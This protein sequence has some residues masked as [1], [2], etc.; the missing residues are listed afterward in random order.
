MQNYNNN[1]KDI[2]ECT[3]RGSCSIS[4]TIA[5]LEVL[6][7]NFSQKM[8]FYLLKLEELGAENNKIKTELI[9]ILASLVSVN[10][11][12]D[13]QFHSIIM[14]EY[15][16]LVELKK[17]YEILSNIRTKSSSKFNSYTTVSQ[18]IAM[19]EKIFLT[20]INKLPL[21]IRNLSEI[22]NIVIK[23]VCINMAKLLDF[24]VFDNNFYHE[25]LE[26]L[27]IFNSKKLTSELLLEKIN[28]LSNYD[29]NLQFEI[30]DSLIR[31]FGQISK[32]K[33]SKSSRKGKS[34]L[35]SGNNFFDLLK[36]LEET[37]DK[38]IDVYTHSNLLIT[39]S[40]E[41]FKSYKNLI[42]HYGDDTENCIIDFATFPGAIL[43]TSNSHGN[44]EYL[45]RGR[46]FSNDYVIPKGVTKIIDN[47]YIPVIDAALIS[48]GFS[49]GKEKGEITVGYDISEVNKVF[50]D[51]ISKL[52]SNN[53]KR[54]YI[55]GI[56]AHSEV[57]KG[58]FDDLFENL[59]KDEV[60]ISFSYSRLKDNIYTI[61]VGN[62]IPLATNLL[63]I[64]FEK[65]SIENP[66]ITFFF[67]NCDVMSISS[68]IAIKN[69][70][71]KNIFMSQCSP[72]LIN[73]SVFDT[74][75]KKYNIKSTT[76]VSNDLNIIRSN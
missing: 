68:V 53:Y 44:N 41:K 17:T 71:A 45:Y 16:M 20:K 10:E 56:D 63:K 49:K 22:L 51:I 42:G 72:M 11:F 57:Q 52:N 73:P 43:L 67:T 58:Y 69:L 59:H 25:I 46:L 23:S 19:G 13:T 48:K 12:N 65:Y 27:N 31:K 30:A 60:V 6:A 54:I 33:V 39:H 5:A 18:A 70:K 14:D 7:I 75:A 24:D 15:Y 38:D 50:S 35:V 34:I 29:K 4:P 3:S 32:T 47:N 2:D 64:F 40:L 55:V 28:L 61:N 36:I 37:K 21:E 1:Y 62:Y 9:K 74:F 26:S 76:N 66:N 8:A